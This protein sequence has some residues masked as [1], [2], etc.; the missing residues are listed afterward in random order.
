MVLKKIRAAIDP[1]IKS[2]EEDIYK[3]NRD[4]VIIGLANWMASKNSDFRGLDASM[5]HL[6]FIFVSFKPDGRS[7]F[8]TS[9]GT[10]P[11]QN[12]Q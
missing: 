10:P 9:K 6:S 2:I 12:N 11:L 7:T 5:L 4:R 8:A 3:V 1:A